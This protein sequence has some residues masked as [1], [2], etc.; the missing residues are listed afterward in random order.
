MPNAKASGLSM[1]RP[2]DV[3]ED[4]SADRVGRALDELAATLYPP[5]VQRLRKVEVDRHGT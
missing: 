2:A 4:S 1:L 3:A 5:G